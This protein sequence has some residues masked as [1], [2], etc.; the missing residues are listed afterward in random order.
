MLDE[1]KFSEFLD[2][3]GRRAGTY[4]HVDGDFAGRHAVDF[5]LETEDSLDVLLNA[6]TES[7]LGSVFVPGPATRRDPEGE[8]LGGH[9]S[10]LHPGPNLHVRVG[11]IG[12][13]DEVLV[14]VYFSSDE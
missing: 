7:A 4:A 8:F 6:F 10:S 3:R 9:A 12:A 14:V 2:H 11:G 5:V 1:S 13:V